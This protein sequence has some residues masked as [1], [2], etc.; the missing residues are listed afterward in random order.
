[1]ELNCHKI[2]LRYR[3]FME[4]TFLLLNC[5]INCYTQ[6]IVNS[7]ASY[8]SVDSNFVIKKLISGGLGFSTGK[9]TYYDYQ[10]FALRSGFKKT[11]SLNIN[12]VLGY[13]YNLYSTFSYQFDRTISKNTPWLADYGFMLI[14]DKYIPNSFF[15]GYM[16]YNYNKYTNS[17]EQVGRSL[18]TGM[19]YV[20]YRLKIPD[21]FHNFLKIT[22]SSDIIMSIQAN[23]T[24][25]YFDFKNQFQG[26]LFDGKPQFGFNLQYII[27]KGFYINGSTVFDVRKKTQSPYTSDYTYGFGYTLG[28]PLKCS[29]TYNN[30]LNKFGWNE[31]SIRS[32]LGYADFGILF[33]YDLEYKRKKQK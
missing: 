17:L 10:S 9:L 4:V 33:Q 21:K 27:F 2:N 25:K 7:P 20:G 26:G 30:S 3:R 23:Y 29:I 11:L 22:S 19:F 1:M 13:H 28:K 15:W 32:G 6:I 12:A 8:S 31:S 18:A 5:S 14:R 24:V 16:N